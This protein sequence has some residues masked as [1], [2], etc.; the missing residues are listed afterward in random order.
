[1]KKILTSVLMISTLIALVTVGTNAFFSDT[2]TSV[3]N[4]LQAGDI[5]L[6]IDNH[7]WYNGEEQEHLSWSLTDLTIERFF[8][9]RDLKPGDWEEDTISIHVGSNDAWLCAATQI[10]LDHDNG[11]TEPEIE[12]GDNVEGDGELDEELNF[13][14]W[15][16]D[17]D[18]VFEKDETIFLGGPLSGLGGAGSIALAD[19][20]GGALG[21]LDGQ[22]NPAGVPAGQDF[23]IG[24][25]FCYGEMTPDPVDTGDNNSPAVDPGFD[26]DGSKVDNQS[27]TDVIVGN[28][29]FYAEQV[30][31]NDEFEC[32]GDLFPRATPFP[33]TS[34]LPIPS[35]V[36]SPVT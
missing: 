22:N 16:D 30:R 21:L 15:V 7:A 9:Y 17:G 11:L 28:L 31:N 4:V 3:D 35:P 20:T 32:S 19:S 36:P 12:D 34:P 33:T 6:Q 24:K 27:Q 13:A 26:C 23:F 29:S 14:F 2:E 10:T 1:M 5:D 18:N 8:D 25:A